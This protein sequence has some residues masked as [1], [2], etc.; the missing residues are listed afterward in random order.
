MS[1]AYV[2]DDTFYYW[3]VLLDF[4][5]LLSG[6]SLIKMTQWI[7]RKPLPYSISVIYCRTSHI[8][9]T[10]IFS[11]YGNIESSFVYHTID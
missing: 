11:I 4:V 10:T 6:F 1:R 3:Q 7:L 8:E 9:V 2:C 5:Y